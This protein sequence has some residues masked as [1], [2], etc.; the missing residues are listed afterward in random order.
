[1]KNSTRF[2]KE[3]MA[4]LRKFTFNDPAFYYNLSMANAC[5]IKCAT[6]GQIF[7]NTIRH[8]ATLLNY[9]SLDLNSLFIDLKTLIEKFATKESSLEYKQLKASISFFVQTG[10][11]PQVTGRIIENAQDKQINILLRCLPE[12]SVERNF[13]MNEV[14][15]N[16]QFSKTE[17][18]NTEFNRIYHKSAILR[19][20]HFI[21]DPVELIQNACNVKLKLKIGGKRRKT[22]LISDQ[23]GE[24]RV[25]ANK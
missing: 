1:M 18:I 8:H 15:H 11:K 12:N 16:P 6:R 23:F 4:L 13:F 19:T 2:F 25:K 5:L 3:D 10:I 17:E 24:H 14:L 7:N 21:N 9:C 22:L 20:M